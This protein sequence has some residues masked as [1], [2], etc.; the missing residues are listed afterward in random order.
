RSRF[1]HLVLENC[2][3]GGGRTDLGMVS[4][5]H[6]TWFSDYCLAPRAVR[7]Q[8]GMMLAL[9]PELLA[10]VCGVV[11]N[12]HRGGDL[13]MQLRMNFLLGNPCLSGFWP[14]PQDA[15]PVVLDRIHRAVALFKT[16]VRPMIA[17]CRVFHHTPEII[18]DQPTGW[19]VIEYA[20][21]D[22]SKAI[23]G[24]F[25][26]AG[27]SEGERVVRFRGVSRAKT[28]SV[29]FDDPGEAAI[30]TGR[31]LAER[32]LTVHLPNPMTSEL[33]LVEESR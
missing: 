4:R 11:M 7:M 13:D 16:H 31:E 5:M 10:R 1:P 29:W 28:Y 9:A 6:F 25:R 20:A 26:L 27:E 2:A 15:H 8:N 23:A 22:A 14:A 21:P 18:G 33:I 19:C 17:T 3:G 24:V 32:G 30:V 12:A